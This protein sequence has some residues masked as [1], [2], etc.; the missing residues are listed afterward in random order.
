MASNEYIYAN[1]STREATGS[2]GSPLSFSFVAGQT[3]S[4]SLRFL[5]RDSAGALGETGL[6]ILNLRAAIG[7]EGAW[8][9]SGWYKIKVGMEPSSSAN[10]T[11]RID[12][13]AG[14]VE[15]EY[16][17]NALTGKPGLFSCDEGTNAILIRRE[18]GEELVLAV[19]A[20]GLRP[21]S[22]GKIYGGKRF[23]D[24]IARVS[25]GE[26]TLVSRVVGEAGNAISI[27]YVASTSGERISVAVS[28]SKITVSFSR[29]PVL[30]K[31]PGALEIKAALEGSVQANALVYASV[32]AD[33]AAEVNSQPEVFLSGGVGAAGGYEYSLQLAQAPVV[34]S[35]WATRSLPSA[36]VISLVQTGGRSAG[37]LGVA[38]NTIQALS[39]PTDFRGAY[40]FQRG[41]SRSRLASKDDGVVAIA[42][43]LNAMLAEEGGTV[44]VT[45]PNNNIAHI[46]F[47]GAFTGYDIANLIISV[48]STPPPDYNL[49]L[50]LG[51]ADLVEML[52][53]RESV[54]LPFEVEA[55]VWI[56]DQDP[57]LGTK[58]IKLWKTTATIKRNVLWDALAVRPP[59]DWLR[60]PSPVDYV[61]FADTQF[62]TGQQAAYTTV[63]GNG[64]ARFFSVVHGLG[65]G[66]E[67]VG[68]SYIYRDE[69]VVSV[70]VRENKPSGRRLQDDEYVLRF[71]SAGS[72]SLEFDA[73]PEEDS[74]VV[75]VLGYGQESAFTIHTHPIDQIKTITEQG[76]TGES[77]RTILEDFQTRIA[78][79]ER[80]VPRGQILAL[81]SSLEKKKVQIPP[82][83][84]ILPDIAYEDRG[85]EGGGSIISQ[86]IAPPIRGAE[87]V[88]IANTE[89]EDQKKA[90]A[91]ELLRVKAEAAAELV[92]AQEA[93]K[94]AGEEIKVK[95]DQEAKQKKTN[96]ISRLSIGEFASRLT[97]GGTVSTTALPH[98]YPTIR[99]GKYAWLLPAI[100]ASAQDVSAVPSLSSAIGNVY[101]NAGSQPLALPGGGGRRGQLVAAGDHFGSDGRAI[102]ALRRSG[103]TTT[104]HPVE[105]ERELIRVMVREGQ[106]PLGS[107]LSISWQLELSFLSSIVVAGAGYIMAIEVAPLTSAAAPPITGVN[108]GV[109]GAA[110]L[111]A[112]PN[113]GFSRSVSETRQFAL[114]L[115]RARNEAGQPIGTSRFMD[116]GVEGSGPTVP[117][118]DF[119]LTVRLE[120]WDVDDSTLLPTGQVGV[121]MP[122]TQMTVEQT[123]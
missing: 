50:D 34:F 8:S 17:L 110:V 70:D 119:L 71:E 112:S 114:Q 66:V 83:G 65:G 90:F 39:V 104:Y 64:S 107:T 98:Y 30:L 86:V 3:V 47:G 22:F 113:I 48:Y 38:W 88:I 101:R 9:E 81:P 87:P 76:A 94:K 10:T 57:S 111:I 58:V 77:L 18:D 16:A 99:N 61:P 80:L 120:R 97:P 75:V 109:A 102:Y 72:V 36:P 51:A 78:R 55:T 63:I 93:A 117:A 35:D 67:Q 116:Y 91:A 56:S 32:L 92:A 13:N 42:R 28:G 89:L 25:V 108:V 73:V 52:Q 27:Q 15:V 54:T 5:Q 69:G 115:V 100:H 118:G 37:S 24:R 82:I 46:E 20:E 49:S 1:L 41:L 84:E 33:G 85:V 14:A 12:Y 44:T 60:R 7:R 19:M 2:T 122:A 105:M 74:L 21:T 79:L 62:L 106:F 40:Q 121:L 59:I 4:Y 45:N 11:A 103:L 6:N 29:D 95:A 43:V 23:P 123:L 68:Q 31:Y 96:V 26:L 53:D